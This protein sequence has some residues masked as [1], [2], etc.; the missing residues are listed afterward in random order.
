MSA[1][2]PRA[3]RS[4]R[5]IGRRRRS[6]ATVRRTG[7]RPR[8]TA[9]RGSGE[10]PARFLSRSSFR[11]ANRERSMIPSRDPHPNLSRRT[12]AT[13]KDA[14]RFSPEFQSPNLSLPQGLSR[15]Q[16]TD[17]EALRRARD[18]HRRN[19][20]RGASMESFDRHRQAAIS[21]L[22]ACSGRRRAPGGRVGPVARG[23][24]P[25]RNTTSGSRSGTRCSRSAGLW[26]R[27]RHHGR[28]QYHRAQ[29]TRY[30]LCTPNGH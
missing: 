12:A 6:P 7:C 30:G 14:W 26:E 18:G 2:C 9:S 19:L 20:D 24:P 21:P 27:S 22:L 13:R 10:P 29:T 17:R 1:R 16:L 25:T 15:A 11:S 4:D 5:E 3:R 8:N 23:P 28:T